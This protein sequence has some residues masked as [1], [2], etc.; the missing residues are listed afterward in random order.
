M[1]SVE[2]ALWILWTASSSFC[3]LTETKKKAHL[4]NYDKRNRSMGEAGTEVKL[5]GWLDYQN[6]L[7][8]HVYSVL[9]MFI[10]SINYLNG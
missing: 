8:N 1:F 4:K 10:F 2:R 6:I 7:F 9:I 3:E 5:C